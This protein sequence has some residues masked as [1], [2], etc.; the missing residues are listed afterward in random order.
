[1]S[2]LFLTLIAGLCITIFLAPVRGDDAAAQASFQSRMRDT[3]RNTMQQLSDAQ[4][5]LA[6]AQAAQA[7]GEKDKAD[8][9]A[10]LDV[11][12]TELKDQT[13]KSAADKD[14]SDKSMA[15]LNAQVAAETKQI[16][17]LDGAIAQWKAAYNQVLLLAKNTEDAR[18]KLAAAKAQL[19]RTVDDRE[20]KNAELYKTGM[21]ILD[22]YEKYGLGEALTAKEP[23][24]G[25]TRV[26]MQ[27]F[28]QDYQDKLMDERVSPGQ[29][30]STPPP[31]KSAAAASEV[32]TAQ[33]SAQKSSTTP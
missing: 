8:L 11:A 28:V 6:A 5:Q 15:T 22:R 17:V 4:G 7:Q 25:T 12:N 20:V 10:K 24:I 33:N 27:T 13:Q 31:K 29:P 9:Q 23:F 26:Q 21:V 30:V 14:T 1:M 16:G 2:R 3:L 18:L 19:E 32:K